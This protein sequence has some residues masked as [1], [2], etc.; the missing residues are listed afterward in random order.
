VTDPRLLRECTLDVAATHRPDFAVSA[1]ATE[2]TAPPLGTRTAALQTAP[3]DGGAA[4]EPGV[5]RPGSDFK[6]FDLERSEPVLCQK[7]CADEPECKAFTYVV[8]GVQGEKA[9]CWLKNTV[10]E[11]LESD[12]CVSG[13]K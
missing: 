7:A 13:V 4:L 11:K 1:A 10:P 2:L 12:C 6:D 5:D 9:R 3:T 8:P